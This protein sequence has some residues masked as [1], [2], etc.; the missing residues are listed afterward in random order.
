MNKRQENKRTMYGGANS[1]LKENAQIVSGVPALAN[2]QAELENK[3][4]EIDVTNNQIQQV[5]AG[6]WITKTTDQ[7]DLSGM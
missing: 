1:T 6:K 3:I 5:V 4:A 7:A 2:A